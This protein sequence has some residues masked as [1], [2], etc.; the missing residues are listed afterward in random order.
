MNQLIKDIK[1][2]TAPLSEFQA[3]IIGLY[4]TTKNMKYLEMLRVA[5]KEEYTAVLAYWDNEMAICSISDDCNTE[6]VK[7]KHLGGYD[8]AFVNISEVDFL[9]ATKNEGSFEDFLFTTL[10]RGIE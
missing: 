9:S 1:Q 4:L 6:E 10:E 2:L 3:Q 5:D 8:H 7:V